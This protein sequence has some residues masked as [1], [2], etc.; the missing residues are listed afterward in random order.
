M[1]ISQKNI[2]KNYIPKGYKLIIILVYWLLV[3][4]FEQKCLTF[5]WHKT[6]K[7]CFLKKNYSEIKHNIL[8]NEFN[9]KKKSIIIKCQKH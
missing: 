9:K 3:S 5:V 7:H 4:K 1:I 2:L 6:M 8:K